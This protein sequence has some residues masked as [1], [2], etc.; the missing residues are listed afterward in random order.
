MRLRLLMLVVLAAI[1]PRVSG[2]QTVELLYTPVVVRDVVALKDSLKAGLVHASNALSVVGV[3]EERRKAYGDNL[4]GA[5]AVVIVGNDALKAVG[6]IPF[7]AP[8]ILVNA[9]RPTAATGRVIRVF[10]AAS[11][12]PGALAVAPS[13][14]A[15]VI[16]SAKQVALKGQVNAVVQAVIAALR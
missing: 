6:D 16:A 11:A 15:A 4:A 10:D 9:A 13:G 2:A 8:V 1:V 3:S 14:V 12:P 7:S 5:T